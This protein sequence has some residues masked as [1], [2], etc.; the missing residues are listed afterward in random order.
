M[1]DQYIVETDVPDVQWQIIE[2]YV[3]GPPGPPGP[4]GS[5]DGGALTPASIGALAA[6]SQL[7]EFDTEQ[8]KS[9][10]RMNLGL[11][12]IDGGTFN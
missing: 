12:T 10:A 3:A 8:K 5:G 9:A 4:P 7:A 6:A 11:Q 1:A 2:V